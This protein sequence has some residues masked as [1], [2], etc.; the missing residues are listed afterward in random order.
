MLLIDGPLWAV[1]P[2][3]AL[4][5]LPAII[6]ID[7]TP[8]P[9]LPLLAVAAIGL[10]IAALFVPRASAE[11]PL[12][13]SV[14]YF[15]DVQHKTA[16]WGVA[17]K[18][19]PLPT[20]FPGHWRKG[21]LPYNG[22]TRWI[23]PAPLVATPVASARVIANEDYGAG[24][25]VRLLLSPGGGDAIAI[26]FPEKTK[27][28]A[29]GLPEGPIPVPARGE[30]DKPILRCAGRSC[31]GLIIEAVLR[32]RAPVVAELFSTRF[33]LPPQGQAL[34][35]A[36]PGNAIPQYSPDETITLTRIRL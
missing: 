11:R 14:D 2:L 4:A 35:E 19:A 8:R 24:R 15:R 20:A 6:E 5:A 17:T 10:W 30:P 27:L 21:L 1:A 36:R 13:F 16:S 31:E 34:E 25:R 32:D 23:E 33:G 12:S 3:A 26:R 7:A 18:Q 28:L 9:L 22:R 29:I